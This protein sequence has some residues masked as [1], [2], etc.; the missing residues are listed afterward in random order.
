MPYS[1]FIC[2]D[3]QETQIAD[4]LK[5]CRIKDTL[6][7]GRCLSIRSLMGMAEQREW[8]G[9]ASTTQLLRGIRE[10]WLVIKHD[11]AIDPQSKIFAMFG[12]KMHDVL[13]GFT[14]EDGLSEQRLH[15]E[16]SSGAFDFYHN[17]VLLDLKTYGSYAVAKTLGL[18]EILV[19]DGFY[20]TTKAGKYK[21]GDPKMK[22]KYVLGGRRNRLDLAIQLNDYRMKLESAGYPVR[23][24][25]CEMLVRDGGTY[26]AMQ[27]GVIFKGC[28]AV[29][30][31]ISDIWIKR[32]MKRKSLLLKHF[33]AENTLPPV[34]R[35]RERWYN[36]QNGTSLKCA[37][38]CDVRFI[39]PFGQ[40]EMRKGG[41][42]SV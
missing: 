30:N 10:S 25:Q 12:T 27:R 2:P 13:D 4:C 9:K 33:L 28:L 34:C 40:R 19:P 6:E 17:E 37:S 42:S 41:D 31:K 8:N 29:I 16:H 7:G 14:P 24:M 11:Y 39:C 22:K 26:I 38:Y 23:E 35:P 32:F 15:D 36:P 5:E 21:A 3:L 18:Q 1:R 20:K